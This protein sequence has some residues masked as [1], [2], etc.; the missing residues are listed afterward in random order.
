MLALIN[1]RKSQ[2]Q[3]RSAQG[4]KVMTLLEGIILEA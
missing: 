1:N 2:K 3:T 4:K